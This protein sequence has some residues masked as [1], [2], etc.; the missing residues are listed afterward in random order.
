[1]ANN[2]FDNPTS[3]LFE[4]TTGNET[5]IGNIANGTLGDASAS[6]FTVTDPLLSKNA[7]GYYEIAPNSPAI[8]A[9]N[10]SIPTLTTY[11]DL[12][13]DNDI[14]YRCYLKF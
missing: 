14:L 11:T 7:E 6:D 2:I 13:F 5:W 8:D 9:S 1:M 12:D 3:E 4:D 10:T